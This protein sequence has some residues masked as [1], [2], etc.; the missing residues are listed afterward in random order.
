MAHAKPRQRVVKTFT[1]C[2]LGVILGIAATLL[3][4]YLYYFSVVPWS[5]MAEKQ[6]RSEALK[7][8]STVIRA[9]QAYERAA[10]PYPSRPATPPT[11]K[12]LTEG[13]FLSEADY[14]KL[15]QEKR[16]DY[17]PTR[18]DVIPQERIILVVHGDGYVV[19]GFASGTVLAESLKQ[20]DRAP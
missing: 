9:L 11:L 5:E 4:G 13:N 16:I 1:A 7:T 6:K 3:T 15:T 2:L 8:V 17:F 19:Y 14:Q 20:P 18:N 12:E 10:L